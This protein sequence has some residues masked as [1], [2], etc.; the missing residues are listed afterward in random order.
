MPIEPTVAKLCTDVF[1]VVAE[2]AHV[3]NAFLTP[4]KLKDCVD[5]FTAVVLTRFSCRAEPA[6]R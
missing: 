3:V 5:W 4:K 6:N 2:D 1:V